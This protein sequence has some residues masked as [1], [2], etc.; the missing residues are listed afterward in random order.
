MEFKPVQ[1]QI[2]LSVHT[3]A[4]IPR[5]S[6]S[7]PGEEGR[8]TL[9]YLTITRQSHVTYARLVLRAKRDRGLIYRSRY[10]RIIAIF[11]IFLRRYRP[12]TV[13]MVRQRF[14]TRGL[15]ASE[16]ILNW[17]GTRVLVPDDRRRFIHEGTR[18]L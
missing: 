13:P 11:C 9:L 10:K 3:D 6:I 12:C 8:L 16:S 5:K 2:R 18:T 14:T 4:D 15:M 7:I 17:N 1:E